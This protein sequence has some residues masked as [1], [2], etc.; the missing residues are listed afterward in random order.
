[1][2]IRQVSRSQFDRQTEVHL[3]VQ[4]LSSVAGQANVSNSQGGHVS[5]LM[6]YFCLWLIRKLICSGCILGKVCPI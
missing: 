5:I 3:S 1:M 6:F 2:G 4:G